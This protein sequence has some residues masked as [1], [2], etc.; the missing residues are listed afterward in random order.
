VPFDAL[1]KVLSG[2]IC[3]GDVGSQTTGIKAPIARAL[4]VYVSNNTN[5]SNTSTST[6]CDGY[7]APILG[8]VR[9]GMT[10]RRPHTIAT[11]PA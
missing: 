4:Y 11:C 6:H 7:L 2:F 8:L 1:D 3:V 10:A 9:T 5:Q